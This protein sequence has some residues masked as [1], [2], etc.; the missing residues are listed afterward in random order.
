MKIFTKEFLTEIGNLNES[1]ISTAFEGFD[2]QDLAFDI[3]EFLQKED[4]AWLESE[5]EKNEEE[6][7]EKF[8]QDCRENGTKIAFDNLPFNF[9]IKKLNLEN[10]EIS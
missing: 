6:I 5:L 2:N 4:N 10:N 3:Y 7:L 1:R 9:L 8:E